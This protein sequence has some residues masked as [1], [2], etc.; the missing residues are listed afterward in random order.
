MVRIVMIRGIPL[1]ICAQICPNIIC[2]ID[3]FPTP[4]EY[5][6]VG[7]PYDYR[8]RCSHYGTVPVLVATL[9]LASY[10]EY[11]YCTSTIFKIPNCSSVR[12]T[13]APGLLQI[14]FNR[15]SAELQPI[16]FKSSAATGSISTPV[17]WGTTDTLLTLPVGQYKRVGTRLLVQH[18][19]GPAAPGLP[20]LPGLGTWGVGEMG[21]WG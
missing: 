7:V 15:R 16:G 13:F 11:E 14:N 10:Y 17:V 21:S 18:Q 4:Y 3:P 2:P 9:P 6:T 19:R 12:L 20:R 5:R 1:R 8:S